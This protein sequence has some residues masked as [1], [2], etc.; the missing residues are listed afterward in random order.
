[1]MLLS[2]QLTPPDVNTINRSSTQLCLKWLCRIRSLQSHL[3]E[4]QGKP[5]C[6]DKHISKLASPIVMPTMTRPAP[7]GS[8]SW[9][10][11]K[12]AASMTP[13]AMAL[14][15]ALQ[16][17]DSVPTK[18]KGTAPRQL[19]AAMRT[20]STNTAPADTSLPRGVFLPWSSCCASWDAVTCPSSCSRLLWALTSALPALSL[21]CA[22]L[23]GLVLLPC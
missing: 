16:R 11:S 7:Y 4:A 18:K 12:L 9:M 14:A 13:Q 5:A 15:K 17:V 1:M 20:V 8:P 22:V 21:T 19:A 10:R 23:C 6:V 2:G 3:L